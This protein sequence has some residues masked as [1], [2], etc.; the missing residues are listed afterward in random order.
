MWEK[1]TRQQQWKAN[2]VSRKSIYSYVFITLVAHSKVIYE[3]GE[4]N[5]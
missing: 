4:Y 2:R 3:K 1:K 5:F